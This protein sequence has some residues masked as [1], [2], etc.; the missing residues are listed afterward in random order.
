MQKACIVTGCLVSVSCNEL[1]T[2]KLEDLDAGGPLWAVE[3][4]FELWQFAVRKH[5]DACGIQF[6]DLVDVE[7][8]GRQ[9]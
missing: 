9:D 1:D 5:G 6:V 4:E 3:I 7:L 2:C 8:L